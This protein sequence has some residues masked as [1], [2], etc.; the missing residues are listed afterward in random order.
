MRLFSSL[1]VL[2]SLTAVA[3]AEP[4]GLTPEVEQPATIVDVPSYR[5]QT[6][7]ADAAVVTLAIVAG[8]SGVDGGGAGAVVALGG[9]L[10]AA[11]I[12]HIAHDH[13]DRAAES[14]AFRVGLPLLGGLIGNV[15][16][17]GQCSYNCDNDADIA[18]TALGVMTGAVAA[19]AVDIGYLSRGETVTRSAPRWS[20]R[21]TAGP[22]GE[23]RVGLGGT[24]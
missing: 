17:K 22:S 13:S 6:A 1:A 10:L 15:I 7:L 5:L 20:P 19:S 24:F 11:P 23:L 16:G 4:P 9:Y 8:K 18:L 12:V 14:I 3:V 21:V 2:G